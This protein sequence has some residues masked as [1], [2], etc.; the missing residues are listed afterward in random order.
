MQLQM[1]NVSVYLLSNFQPKIRERD[2]FS[3][4]ASGRKKSKNV[5]FPAKNDYSGSL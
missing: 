4:K 2:R 5:V 1:G 3:L